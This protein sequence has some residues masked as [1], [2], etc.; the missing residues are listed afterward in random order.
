MLHNVVALR[1]LLAALAEHAQLAQGSAEFQKSIEH[2]L[3]AT[4][5]QERQFE[6]VQLPQLRLLVKEI[7]G[8]RL[9]VG[10]SLKPQ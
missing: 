3:D 4:L 6:G 8:T 9:S 2:H 7:A 5:Q 1:V 10:L